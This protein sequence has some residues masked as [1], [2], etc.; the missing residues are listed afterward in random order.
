MYTTRV[1]NKVQYNMAGKKRVVGGELIYPQHI[2]E[3]N[4]DKLI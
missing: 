3:V 4:E 1:Y 2:V